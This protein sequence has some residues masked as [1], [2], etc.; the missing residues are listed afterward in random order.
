MLSP[1][2]GPSFR[3]LE[4][5]KIT[6]FCRTIFVSSLHAAFAPLFSRFLSKMGA[7]RVG[8]EHSK[9]VPKM[10]PRKKGQNKKVGK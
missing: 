1:A 2:P 10:K 9:L 4:H 7:Q 6:F 5:S 3:G 8:K